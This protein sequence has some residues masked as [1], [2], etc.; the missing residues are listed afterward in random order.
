MNWQRILLENGGVAWINS[1]E[2][3]TTLIENLIREENG[4][5]QRTHYARDN[6]G[7]GVGAPIINSSGENNYHNN[8]GAP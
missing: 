8:P 4:L 6:Y 7:D 2:V 5:P 1:S 3:Y